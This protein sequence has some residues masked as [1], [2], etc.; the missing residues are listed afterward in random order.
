MPQRGTS[1]GQM[2]VA[3][4][5]AGVSLADPG[6]RDWFPLESAGPG[7]QWEIPES[8]TW[9]VRPG[10]RAKRFDPG[11]TDPGELV[12]FHPPGGEWVLLVSPLDYGGSD[13]SAAEVR[14]VEPTLWA[15]R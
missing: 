14:S 15:D 8:G 9:L 10:A 1:P 7:G 12:T 13:E 2:A 5:T 3:P 11:F 4:S 6:F